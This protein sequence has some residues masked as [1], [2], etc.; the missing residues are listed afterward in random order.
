VFD[1][2][3]FVEDCREAFAADPTHKAVREVL[4]RAI[5]DPAAV[6][7]GLGEPRRAGIELLYRSADLTVFNLVWAP[8]MSV[9]PHNHT[10]WALIGIYGGREDNI[11]WQR[12]PGAR[13]GRQIEAKAARSLC[14][15]DVDVLG[16]DIIHSVLNPIDGLT[17]AIH[18]YGGDLIAAERSEWHAETLAEGRVDFDRAHQ[19][20]EEANAALARS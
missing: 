12:V 11:F 3:R 4:A 7:R 16:R 1:R 18:I 5:D 20:L 17:G 19:R 6:I 2:E 10:M 8:R 14:R 9:F 15:G 13:G